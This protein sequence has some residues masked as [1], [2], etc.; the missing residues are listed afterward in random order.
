MSMGKRVLGKT[1]EFFFIIGRVI[2]LLW[3]SS[4]ATFIKTIGTSIAA[5]ITI[6]ITLLVWK[7][8]LDNVGTALV[9]GTVRSVLGSR[10]VAMSFKSDRSHVV[11]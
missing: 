1:K 8:L 4:K 2:N 6:P 10:I 3:K 5:G 9:S 11:L 7:Y